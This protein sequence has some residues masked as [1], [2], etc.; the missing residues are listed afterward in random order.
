MTEVLDLDSGID[1]DEYLDFFKIPVG[2]LD[3]Q[4]A[5]HDARQQIEG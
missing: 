2:P 4:S 1:T 5:D 3:H